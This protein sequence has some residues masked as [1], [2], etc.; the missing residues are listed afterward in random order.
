[1]SERPFPPGAY[2][3]VVVGSG[4]G[5]LQVSYCL[6]RLGVRRAT[7]SA[8][9]APAGMFQ[10]W[11]VYQRLISWTKLDAPVAPSTRDYE[12]YDHNS[13]VA[14]DDALRGLAAEFI[15]RDHIV[16]SRGEMQSA[17]VAF[18]DRG[19]VHVRYG[20]RWESTTREGDELVLRTTDGEYRCRAAVFAVGMTEP[21]KSPIEGIEH[22]PHYAESEE[23][24][25]YR[26]KDV[27]IIGKRNSGF[28]IATGLL[29][30]ARRLV[31]VSPRPVQTAVLAHATVRVR[32]LQ[33][34]EAAAR[35]S[36][37]FVLDAAID[38]VERLSDG[39]FRVHA[40][41][42]TQPSAL[43]LDADAVIVATG[44]TTPLGD[45]RELGVRTV[46]QDRL[47]AL[48]PLWESATA[49]GVFF[50]GSA[51]LGAAGLRKHGVVS[52]SG[53]VQGFRYNA[54]VLAEHLAERV[55]GHA[56]PRQVVRAD[57][58]VPTLAREL[59]ASPELWAQK[60]YLAR[61]FSVDG[62]AYRDDR[63]MPL[64]HF[65]D[66]AGPD[67]VAVTVETGRDGAIYPVVYVRR[68]GEVAERPLDPHPL[69]A[70]D[71]EAYRRELASLV[72]A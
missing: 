18:A 32:Y 61:A 10:R 64:E 15:G 68:R 37:T 70:F 16:P 34:F 5:G 30:W 1:M 29:P 49:E 45:L 58:L 2:D 28:E 48:T 38:R 8:D 7:I 50:A 35:G 22:A 52:T 43:T 12:W 13:L 6:D 72:A 24:E 21:W 65:V 59:A 51:T 41:G 46:A 33:P 9:D 19:G 53:G 67:G 20:C 23:P 62:G 54:R 17:L 71:G 27:V 55:L 63:A 40:Q 11:P 3:V 60:G 47:P 56:L 14:E 42:T 39:R 4:P 25:R 31:L 44:F 69:F 36:G 66:A 57:A 26:G